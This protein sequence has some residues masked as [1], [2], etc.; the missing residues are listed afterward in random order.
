MNDEYISYLLLL[1]IVDDTIDLALT[2]KG[3]E[4]PVRQY[5]RHAD[6]SYISELRI[7]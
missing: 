1:I 5:D 6:K 7:Q 4:N 3:T 2:D